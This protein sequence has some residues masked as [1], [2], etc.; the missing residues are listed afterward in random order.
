MLIK[1]YL[2]IVYHPPINRKVIVGRKEIYQKAIERAGGGPLINFRHNNRNVVGSGSNI[3][4]FPT[5]SDSQFP[6]H[7]NSLSDL[8]S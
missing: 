1:N 7:L 2:I 4:E 5:F 8:F 3:S 6:A